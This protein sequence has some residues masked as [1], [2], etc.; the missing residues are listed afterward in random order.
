[1]GV[2]FV[3]WALMIPAALAWLLAFILFRRRSSAR[4]AFVV[5]AFA[6]SMA[7]LWPGSILIGLPAIAAA[8]I[9]IAIFEWA[10]AKERR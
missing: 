2:V 7:A 4:V 6:A 8:A 3:T 9:A 10:A 1:M 5:L